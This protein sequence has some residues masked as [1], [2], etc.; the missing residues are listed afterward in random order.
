MSLKRVRQVQ[1][2][3]WPKMPKKPEEVI[4]FLEAFRREFDRFHLKMGDAATNL[5]Y[6]GFMNVSSAERGAMV[7]LMPGQTVFD[8]N[9]GKLMF[10]DGATW[11]T[12]TS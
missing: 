7:D 6:F 1:E 12:I 4:T 10:W 5:K 2:F 11:Q 3:Q 8:T 9:L